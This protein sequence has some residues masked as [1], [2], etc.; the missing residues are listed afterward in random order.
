M[1]SVRGGRTGKYDPKFR[2]P[3]LRLEAEV[4]RMLFGV[5][6]GKVCDLDSPHLRSFAAFVVLCS[7][8]ASA[9]FV[10]SDTPEWQAAD[11]FALDVL[12]HAREQGWSKPMK[13]ESPKFTGRAA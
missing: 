7:P 6:E 4:A 9:E 5:P 10:C 12:Q 8:H 2:A 13:G 1:D 11:A 3:L